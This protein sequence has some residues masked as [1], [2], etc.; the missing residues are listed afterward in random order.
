MAILKHVPSRNKRFHDVILYLTKKHDEDTGKPILDEHGEMIDRE[1]F[2]IDGINCTPEDFAELALKDAVHFNANRSESDV[3]THQ[4]ILSFDPKDAQKGL[5]LDAAFEEGK[6]FAKKNF[7]GHRVIVAAH[8]DGEQGSKNIHVHIIVTAVRFESRE[9]QAEFM[10]LKKDGVTV[11]ESEYKAGCKHQDTGRLRRYLNE[12]LQ[13]Y[14]REN[15][16]TVLEEKPA[17]KVTNKEYMAKKRGQ[18]KLDRDNAERTKKGKEPAQTKFVSKKDEMRDIVAHA[19]SISKDWDE[20][21]YNLRNNYTREVELR[22]EEP[23]IPYKEGQA[24]WAEY[25]KVNNEFW[26]NHR[27]RAERFSADIKKEYDTLKKR[28]KL[29]WEGRNRKNTIA[30]RRQAYRDLVRMDSKEYIQGD[31][32]MRQEG[33]QQLY[34][35]KQVYQN[36]AAAMKM[37]LLNGMEKEAR[38][39]LSRLEE[40]QR[41]QDGYWSR[42]YHSDAREYKME[43]G[44]MECLSFINWRITSEKELETSWAWMEKIETKIA[45]NEKVRK[46]PVETRTEAFP[47]DVKVSRGEIS[48]KHPDLERWT[49]GSSLGSDYELAAIEK[50]MEKNRAAE[51]AVDKPTLV[52]EVER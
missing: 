51:R 23:T 15:G 30:D 32:K 6:R 38:A 28:R 25:K 1:R 9:P 50:I 24:L 12:Q 42:G 27:A 5:T 43:E 19:A 52:A 21:A 46:Q 35:H 13:E 26:I 36:Y 4:Y 45:E 49:R 44:T 17:K 47:F 31:I 29:E 10:K 40:L 37:A 22:P 41:R 8:P 3:T 33:R 18:K 7:P 16:Y 34:L 11:K 14:C 48:F 20:L 39:C 2:L